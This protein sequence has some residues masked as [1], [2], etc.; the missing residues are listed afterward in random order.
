MLQ[1][2]LDALVIE[3]QAGNQLALD[4]LV[5]YLH[6]ALLAFA[7]QYCGNQTLAQDAV[8]EA[9]L[10]GIG[11]LH[12]LQ[13]PRVFKPWMIKAVKWRLLDLLRQQTRHASDDELSDQVIEKK[14]DASASELSKLVAGLPEVEK[15]A[16]LLFY[17]QELQLNEIALVQGVPL[18]TVKSRLNRAKSRIKLKLEN[19]H[20]LG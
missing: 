15:E 14:P 1:A 5:R 16:V 12:K 13:D 19:H 9:W 10:K 11:S 8:Q 7:C 2:E 3:A 20:E 6:P 17:Q 4:C 18:G